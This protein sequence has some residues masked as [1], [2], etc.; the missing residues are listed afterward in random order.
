MKLAIT[1]PSY[2]EE[3]TIGKVIDEIPKKIPGISEI[4]IIV[5]DDGSLDATSKIAKSKGATVL[6]NRCNSGLA[7]SFSRGL[8]YAI[9]S[10]ADIIVNTDGDFQYNQKQIPTLLGPIMAQE[11]DI[12]L[13]SRFAGKI[14]Y[15]PAQ[16]YWG[17]RAM[18]FLVRTLTGLDIS[19]AQTGFRAFSRD[20]AMK[21]NIVSSYTYTQETILEAWE[22]KLVIK[23]VPVDFRRRE[24]KSRLISNVFVYAR[25]AGFTVL[26]TYLSYK[27][28]K[29]F[30]SVGGLM[31]LGGLA[32][33][34]RVLV[35]YFKFGVV[36]PYLPT[37]LL[38]SVLLVVGLQIVMIGLLA[39]MV[40]RSRI[41]QEKMLYEQ[42]KRSQLLAKKRI[43]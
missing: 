3:K 39:R 26:E 7:F 21:L 10:G 20:A 5:I 4:E 17:N 12:V 40:Q 33:G 32:A 38:S 15:M 34:L 16:N 28:L 25:R 30:L 35:H 42:R 8:E 11:A 31:M 14:E 41:L 19:D 13:G 24:G 43:N 29:L 36:E 27:P 18:S 1:I 37:A 2:N 6:C 23:E 9:E 22:K